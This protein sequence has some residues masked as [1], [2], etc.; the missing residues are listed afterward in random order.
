VPVAWVTHQEVPDPGR[1][2]AARCASFPETGLVPF[3]LGGLH[4]D[5]TR[6]W[7]TEEFEYPCDPARI[8]QTGA[9]EVLRE[10]W[11]GEMPSDEEDQEVCDEC[12]GKG[13]HDI[14]RITDHPLA[15]P[16]WTFWWD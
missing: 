6:P 9:A 14:S 8:D 1:V 2:W 7:D 10:M 15:S 5:P 12:A 16:I 11:D 3:L 4:G 13:L